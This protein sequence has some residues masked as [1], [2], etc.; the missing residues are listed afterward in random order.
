VS[1]LPLPDL[2]PEASHTPFSDA[3]H[4]MDSIHFSSL[5]AYAGQPGAL[6]G[7]AF[8]PRA[9]ARIIDMIIHYTITICSGFL[10]G[11]LL[12]TVA[13][14]RHTR[15]QVLLAHR[16]PGGIT[17]FVLA[18]LASVAFQAICE[19]LHGSSPGKR[20]FSIVVV[21]ED[22]SPCRLGSAWTRSFAYFI[23]SLFFG[24]VGYFNMQKTPQQQR[25]GDDWAHTIVSHRSSVAPQNLSGL[26]Q[27]AAATF[28]A[29][30]AYSTLIILGLLVNL[31]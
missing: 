28:L 27:F 9:G 5:D 1:I 6:A 22:A 19:G 13:A 3:V 24:L 21:Q 25:H 12:A 31:T 17:L 4:P 23:D 18:L 2:T 8:W 10:F 20:L 15:V 30:L 7:V 14:L 29:T 26:G 16:R 11:A